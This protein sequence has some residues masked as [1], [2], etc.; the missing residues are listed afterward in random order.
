MIKLSKWA[1]KMGISY[2]TAYRLWRMDSLFGIKLP[3]GTILIDEEA[4]TRG[5]KDAEEKSNS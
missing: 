1:K 4:G 2:M 5:V 3:T